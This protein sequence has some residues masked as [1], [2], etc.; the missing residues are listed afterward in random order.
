MVTNEFARM[1]GALSYV[2]A[3]DRDTWLRMGMSIK[4]ALGED[5]FPLWSE[6]SQQDES[7]DANSARATWKSINPNG[8][9]TGA[10]LFYEARAN[11][12][13][14]DNVIRVPSAEQLAARQLASHQRQQRD[15]GEIAREQAETA[16]LAAAIW[17]MATAAKADNPYLARKAVFPVATLREIEAG[18]V[19]AVLGYS[20]K[21]NGAAL[22]GRLLV[23]PIKRAGQLS[24]LEL[25]D[26][27]GQKAALCGRGTRAGGFWATA[28]KH[29]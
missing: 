5:G 21:S 27:A 15:D 24:T 22:S 17:S 9:I 20:P 1:Q 11:G 4:S 7:Y 12:W 29:L 8:K 6:W 26:G 10:T 23:A 14:D 19:A 28:L 18:K 3:H 2:P 16:K 13:R 25:I